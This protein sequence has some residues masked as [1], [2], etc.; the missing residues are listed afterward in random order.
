MGAGALSLG[1]RGRL[2]PLRVAGRP[3]PADRPRRAGP[4]AGKPGP[5]APAPLPL[6]QPAIPARIAAASAIW[7]AA[8]RARSGG[9]SIP[10]SWSL[11]ST[12]LPARAE[13]DG[14]S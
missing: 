12:L 13:A 9:S 5:D 11:T 7:T 2:R 4:Q 1:V 3:V 10:A 6:N 8:T 14:G